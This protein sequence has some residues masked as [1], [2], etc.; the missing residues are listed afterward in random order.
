M[1]FFR[2][3]GEFLKSNYVRAIAK[4]PEGRTIARELNEAC[5][6]GDLAG[7]QSIVRKVEAAA[8]IHKTLE[9]RQEEAPCSDPID[10]GSPRI[11]Y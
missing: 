9:T 7:V 6:R 4:L 11:G 8:F 5:G 2:T 1:N 3:E 10:I